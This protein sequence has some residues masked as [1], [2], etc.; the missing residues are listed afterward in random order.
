MKN[1]DS[2]KER[3]MKRVKRKMSKKFLGALIIL[4]MLS[5]TLLFFVYF[6][7]SINL[8][9]IEVKFQDDAVLIEWEL[10]NADE[11]RLFLYDGK[12]ENYVTDEQYQEKLIQGETI[13][14][15]T[16]QNG[17]ILKMNEG[18]EINLCL[19]AV[20]FINLFGHQIPISGRSRKLTIY[21]M[22]EVK[23]YSYAIPEEKIAFLLWQEEDNC[24]YEVYCI[25]DGNL[26]ET[27]GNNIIMLD[28]K[29][30]FALPDRSNPF[31]AA[32]RVVRREKDYTAYGPISE[33]VMISRND[34]LESNMSL[35]WEQIEERQYVL[36]WQESYGE[37][38]E[39]QQWS[40]EQNRWISK[41]T[42]N[43]TQ[44]MSYQ[45]EHLPSNVQVRFRVI[46]Y[47][48]EEEA[49]R[50]EFQTE[51]SEVTF[52]TGMSPLYCTVWPVMPLKIMDQPQE[53]E[54]LGEVPAGQ[55]LC[56]L[57]EE[58]G[59]FKIRYQDCSGYIDSDYCLI[60]LPEYLGDLCEYDITNSVSS[61]FRVHEYDILEITGSV[62]RGYENICLG[63]EDYVVP[64][65]YPCTEKLY[66]AV[67][68]ASED[69]Y[70][71]RIYDAFRPNEATGY[72]YETVEALLGQP[73]PIKIE[74][75][76]TEEYDENIE[77]ME[78]YETEEQMEEAGESPDAVQTNDGA[79]ETG[80][81]EETGRTEDAGSAENTESADETGTVDE[82]EMAGEA[83][84]RDDEGQEET[85]DTYWFI[86]TD[87]GRYRLGSFLASSVSAHNFGIA[88]DLTLIDAETKENLPMQTQM[89]DLSWYSVTGNNNEN[90]ILLS[91]YMKDAGFSDL[92]TEWWH[93]QD[94][95]T[96]NRI[97]HLSYLT[98]GV[99]VEGWK[100]DDTGWKYRLADGSYY[101][102]TTVEIDGRESVFDKEG[103]CVREDT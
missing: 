61:I 14:N 95:D 41:C 39:V 38:Y 5:L 94:N 50:E 24:E 81:K 64:Y 23:L 102:N 15:E 27:T 46:T 100:R 96:R 22:E 71:L 1:A 20:K 52:H 33:Y 97:G 54:L 18:E 43:A 56:V 55:A 31:R 76:E 90:A 99:S 3:N 92:V 13:Q 16:I 60:N 12:T 9:N 10:I 86:M 75:G 82:T 32:V 19:Q 59:S 89:H 74:E 44:E 34:L 77:R 78:Y 79:D 26:W 70:A 73:V 49:D 6:Y 63:N 17:V 93:F 68:N 87:A 4:G 58:D 48:N 29:N 69:G 30:E 53:G 25:N 57:G 8:K 51:P 42:L 80:T 2:E 98:Q 65:L 91:Q 72:L 7:F 36:T 84:S 28:F 45:T 37:W 11:C 47:N 83:G 101:R 67:L 62:V 35:C 88:L 40:E 103:Y 21:P 85:G 66:Q